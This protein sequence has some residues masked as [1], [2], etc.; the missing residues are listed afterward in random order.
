LHFAYDALQQFGT[1]RIS[2][3]GQV[4]DLANQWRATA[5]RLL[6]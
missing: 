1:S 3:D 5:R 4:P 2:Q 6:D